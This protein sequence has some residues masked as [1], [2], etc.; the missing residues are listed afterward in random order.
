MFKGMIR[1][2]EPGDIESIEKIFD[3]YWKDNFRT[4]LSDRL[5][6][7]D[8][9]LNWV[10]AEEDGEVVGVAAYR[11]APERM[12][13]YTK[14]DN[15]VEFYV[16]AVKNRRQGI[17]TALLRKRLDNVKAEGYEEAV[18]FSGDTHQDSWAFHDASGFKRVGESVAPN[19]EHGY[20]WSMALK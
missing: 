4:H 1:N 16:A 10:V 13:Q 17:G 9:G 20:I 11:D 15:V 3:L 8:S 19:G 18:F 14:S 12:R 2:L 7:S 5:R 6:N